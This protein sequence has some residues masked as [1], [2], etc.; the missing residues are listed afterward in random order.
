VSVIQI[1]ENVTAKAT[2]MLCKM[3]VLIQSI[4][5]R[6]GGGGRGDLIKGGSPSLNMMQGNSNATGN[7]MP[8]KEVV[9]KHRNLCLLLLRK[10]GV[11]IQSIRRRWGGGS[12]SLNLMQGNSNATVNA[13]PT[14]LWMRCRQPQDCKDHP[15][16]VRMPV[17]KHRYHGCLDC[18]RPLLCVY[19]N[20]FAS[21]YYLAVWTTPK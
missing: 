6:W 3:G 4:R 10:M 20:L 13:M 18:A 21:I 7:A 16:A 19:L 17:N 15:T 5:R 9:S 12:P 1:R 2:S 8:T 11:L 14:K